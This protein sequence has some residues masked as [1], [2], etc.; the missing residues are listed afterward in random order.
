MARWLDPTVYTV[1]GV[2]RNGHLSLSQSLAHRSETSF[3]MGASVHGVSALRSWP[4][5]HISLA[6]TTW[7]SGAT[8]T[9]SF[10]PSHPTK[11][12]PPGFELA[13][14]R[15]C[16]MASLS[17]LP[18]DHLGFQPYITRFPS[19]LPFGFFY[20]LLSTSPFS[21]SLLAGHPPSEVLRPLKFP[22]PHYL[23]CLSCS[24][25]PAGPFTCMGLASLVA[26]R[27]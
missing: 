22:Y 24:H 25:R 7:S 10:Q 17:V 23:L 11:S 13:T 15:K 8:P 26:V 21:V 19:Y 1:S 14:S 2:V 12:P 16:K 6:R 20:L 3:S 18:L 5:A 9:F 4:P 27:S